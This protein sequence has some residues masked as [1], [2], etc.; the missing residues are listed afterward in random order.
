MLHHERLSL[1]RLESLQRGAHPAAELLG[2]GIV[3]RIGSGPVRQ[4]RQLVER[5]MSTSCAQTVPTLV[6]EDP[7]EPPAH[8]FRVSTAAQPAK[9]PHQRP[10]HQVRGLV[11][12]VHHADRVRE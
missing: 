1:L 6:R 11:A 2:V 4:R 3:A 7:E 12:P 8:A 9:G 10:L 5:E